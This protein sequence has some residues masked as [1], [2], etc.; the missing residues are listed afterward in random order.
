M[1]CYKLLA[2]NYY[3][4][5][6]HQNSSMLLPGNIYHIYNRANGFEN[7]FRE[8]KNYYFFLSK[9]KEH[10]C[11]VAD[12]MAWNLLANHFHLMVK[13]KSAEEILPKSDAILQAETFTQDHLNLTVSKKFSN[14][15]NAYTKAYNKTYERK[16][17]LFQRSF[18]H[19]QVT[20]HKYFT[21]LVLYIHNNA[22]KHGFVSHFYDWPHSSWF[23]Y[24]TDQINKP[25]IGEHQ[26]IITPGIQHEV[27]SWFGNREAFLK[28]HADM[29]NLNSTFE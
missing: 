28:A 25:M 8:E 1:T 14:C 7:L 12:V 24:P 21:Q 5:N 19:K 6:F 23:H 17:S 3:F 4:N 15:F 18:K 29:P 27:L 13:I 2:G 11:P 9:L 10:V 22:A 26:I 20:H 16:G